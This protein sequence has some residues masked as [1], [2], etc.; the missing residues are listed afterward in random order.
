MSLD[1]T[2]HLVGLDNGDTIAY[3]KLLIA[4]GAKP[5]NL[6][7]PGSSLSGVR[8]LRYLSDAD[9]LLESMMKIKHATVV[10]GGFIT[11][12]IVQALSRSG[13]VTTVVNRSPYYWS[14][15]LDDESGKLIDTWLESAASV[16]LL[17]GTAVEAIEGSDSV[18]AVLLSNGR[19]LPTDLIMVNT[20]VSPDVNWLEGSGLILESGVQ[21]NSQLQTEDSSVWAA[22]DIACFDDVMARVRHRLGNWQNSL[23]HG[24]IAGHNMS[25]SDTKTFRQLSS[26]SISLFG[27]DI[28][29]IGDYHTHARIKVVPRGSARSGHYARFMIRDG[30]MVGATMLDRFGE[31]P[32][33]EQ[34]IEQQVPLT[35]SDILA[36]TDETVSLRDYLNSKR[37][38]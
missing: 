28:T 8:S 2:N 29:F 36:L 5:R 14:R 34:L 1:T 7:I 35:S 13:I 3:E 38:R 17:Y 31:R 11:L 9:E 6:A 19:R 27:H 24:E 22:G 37:I 4:G 33:I 32:S 16:K 25:S 12:D 26:Y 20:G 21:V 30:R 15:L 23:A 10:G 18:E